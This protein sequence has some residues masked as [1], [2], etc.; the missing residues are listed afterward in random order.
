MTYI[1]YL[2]QFKK[3]N[4]KEMMCVL[5]NSN[6]EFNIIAPTYIAKLSHMVSKLR[7]RA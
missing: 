5:I 4:N 2:V 1:H 7:I 6:S 3:E